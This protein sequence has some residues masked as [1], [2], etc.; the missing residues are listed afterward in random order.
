MAT[1]I[2]AVLLKDWLVLNWR[3]YFVSTKSHDGTL[4]L[5]ITACLFQRLPNL[6]LGVPHDQVQYSE[7][8]KD[9]GIDELPVTW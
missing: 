3:L 4:I 8:H 6:K 1:V 5:T 7:A 2:T 9:V